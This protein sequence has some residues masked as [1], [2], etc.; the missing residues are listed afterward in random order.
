MVA[1]LRVVFIAFWI[2][3]F[4]RFFNSICWVFESFIFRC[5]WMMA[6][7]FRRYSFWRGYVFPCGSIP[8]G[9]QWYSMA[10][11]LTSL[12]N[13][14]KLMDFC[15]LY[16]Y[17]HQYILQAFYVVCSVSGCVHNAPVS[18]HCNVYARRPFPDALSDGGF[19]VGWSVARILVG[20]AWIQ[21]ALL[22]RRVFGWRVEE[23]SCFYWI[24]LTMR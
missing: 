20:A 12:A 16:K 22:D 10:P 21:C 1:D 6:P 9:R 2:L 17:I 23:G 18:G 15:L 19:C 13:G 7:L 11:V 14:P 24:F 8:N 3:C 4:R 5:G